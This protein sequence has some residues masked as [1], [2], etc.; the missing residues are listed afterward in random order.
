M[1]GLGKNPSKG[2]AFLQLATSTVS[3]YCLELHTVIAPLPQAAFY[4][5]LAIRPRHRHDAYCP[6]LSASRAASKVVESW[7]LPANDCCNSVNCQGLSCW[8]LVPRA[9]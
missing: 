3:A 7:L 6:C 1:R 9:S 5:P 8:V 4:L 2:P